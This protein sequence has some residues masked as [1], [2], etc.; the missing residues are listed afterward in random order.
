M[1]A[2]LV[3]RSTM[4]IDSRR[5]GSRRYIVPHCARVDLKFLADRP[6]ARNISRLTSSLVT[7]FLLSE[8]PE[9]K[10]IQ[11]ATAEGGD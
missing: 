4:A 6:A 11:S 7:D 8:S 3:T 9:P 10:E 5:L 1:D 2:N